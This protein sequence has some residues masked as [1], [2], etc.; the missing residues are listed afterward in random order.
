MYIIIKTFLVLL[1][2]TTLLL[3][4]DLTSQ[5]KKMMNSV[6]LQTQNEVSPEKTIEDKKTPTGINYNLIEEI[7]KIEALKQDTFEATSEFNSRRIAAITEL[8][9]KIKFFGQ[10]TSKEY[11]AGTAQMKSYDADRERMQLSLNW[12]DNLKS[13]FSE[14]KNL[15]TVSLNISRDEAKKLFQEKKTHYFH[16]DVAYINNKLTISK[17]SIYDKYELSKPIQKK[18]V[19]T[20]TE[21]YETYRPKPLPSSTTSERTNN[22]L[23]IISF[24]ENG[25]HVKISYPRAIKAGQ[26]FVIKVT[27]TNS[28][29][30]AKQGG[31]TLS[32][33][34]MRS[35][36]GS[37]LHNNFTSIKG[38]GYPDKIYNKQEKRAIPANYFMVEGWQSKKWSYGNTK[39]FSV[40][41]VAPH[42][43]SELRV[44][45][46]AVLWIRN[47]HDIREIPKNG[48]TYDQQGFA[49]KQ[50]TIHIKQ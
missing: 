23:Q 9:N 32:F 48:L 8:Q 36:S 19:N 14:I 20:P 28:Y 11:S 27:M 6:P 17:M 38:Y 39:K 44:N 47:K 3:S 10:N 26:R 1:L 13:A 43:V 42:S 5:Y 25:I 22:S 34:D 16:I 15:K 46:R 37:I 4:E 50:F 30:R 18:K 29:S 7:K 24:N 12:N 40:E 41:F 31:L 33:P 49:V 21:K 35:M 45:A 2:Y